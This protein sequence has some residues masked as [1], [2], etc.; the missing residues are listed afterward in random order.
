[1]AGKVTLVGAGPG[2]AALLTLKGQ[3]ALEQAEV[4]VYDRLVDRE[5]LSMIPD[6]ARRINVGKNAGNHPVPQDEINHILLSE[7]LAGHNVVRL[8]GGDSVVFGRGGEELELLAEHDVPFEVVPGI[9]SALAAAAYA[10]IPVT[11]RDYC[12]SVHIITGHRRHDTDLVMDYDAL[13]RLNGTLVFM[14]SVATFAEISKG[15]IAAGMPDDHPCAIVENGTR[16]EQRSFLTTVGD[17]QDCILREKI[18][19][20]AVFIVGRVCTLADRMNWFEHLPLKGVSVYAARPRQDSHRLSNLLRE[21]GARVWEVPTFQPAYLDFD[22]P[23]GNLIFSE[24]EAVESLFAMLKRNGQDARI[25]AG[26][27]LIAGS[28]D[29]QRALRAHGI[30][31]DQPD[32][33]GTILKREDDA[34]DGVSVWRRI[35]PKP[36]EDAEDAP[37]VLFTTLSGVESFEYAMAG[38][39]LRTIKAVC[40]GEKTCQAAKMLGMEAFQARE[41]TLGSLIERLK[42]IAS[43]S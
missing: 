29:A 12:S 35:P 38:R 4:V 24:A 43:E 19:A 23:D 15:L 28:R 17:A 32:G 34:R 40:I 5:I 3:C 33:M 41:C 30:I 27:R 37:F 42:E 36:M 13:V 11:H 18:S 9:T 10:G 8:K 2:D 31:A 20:P 21:Q 39:D 26:R 14:M 16:P 22:L 7:A 25:L 6:S 1:M